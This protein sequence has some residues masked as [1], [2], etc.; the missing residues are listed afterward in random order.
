MSTDSS[1]AVENAVEQARAN[2]EKYL[3]SRIESARTSS[4]ARFGENSGLAIPIIYL[5]PSKSGGRHF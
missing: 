2:L 1:E 5:R 3:S 4:L